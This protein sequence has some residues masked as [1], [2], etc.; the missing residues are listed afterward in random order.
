MQQRALARTSPPDE[1]TGAT[2]TVNNIGALGTSM[3]TS[4]IQ[5]GTTALIAIGRAIEQPVVRDGAVVIRPIAE[6]ALAF[7]HRAIDGGVAGKF[8]D[9]IAGLLEHPVRGFVA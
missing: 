5:H 9:R 3:G 4:I 1:L 6:L 8:I 7:D 2:F